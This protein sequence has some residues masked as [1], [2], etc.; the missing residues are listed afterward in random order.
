MKQDGA[1]FAALDHQRLWAHALNLLGRAPQVV[2][3]RQHARF[4]VVDQ[5]K[6]PLAMVESSSSR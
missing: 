6:V 1:V 3:A 2:V 4:A 5:Q